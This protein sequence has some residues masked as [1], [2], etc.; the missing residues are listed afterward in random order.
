MATKNESGLVKPK[1][2][3]V[4]DE[5]I[6]RS[7]IVDVLS[8]GGFDVFATSDGEL[9]L[10]QFEKTP[11]EIV[12]TDLKMLGLNG[13]EVIKRIKK[14]NQLATIIVITA[15]P[16]IETVKEALLEGA[17][18][19][20]S[21]PFDLDELRIV[22]SRAL[23]EHLLIK[24]KEKYKELAILDGLTGLY[25][26]RYLDE[27]L[28]REIDRS[29]R[30]NRSFIILLIDIDDFKKYNDDNSHLAGD[31]ILRRI[32]Q[33]LYNSIRKVDFAFRYGGDEFVVIL[34]E[35]KKDEAMEVTNRIIKSISGAQFSYIDVLPKKK[36]TLSIGLAVYPDDAKDNNG[37][38]LKAD[39]AMYLAKAKGKGRVCF[40]DKSIE[41]N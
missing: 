40:F 30:Y 11:F 35:V 12:I 13:I 14:I 25:N 19:Y 1:V 10:A 6:I 18:D 17:Y 24:E 37:L 29:Q 2:L 38:L 26:R 28:T 5:K 20:L 4:D 3:V 36:M 16:S 27:V 22:I 32:G 7:L 39:Q 31:E 9:A 23:K 15:Y 8:E 33:L 21:K 41:E 34:P